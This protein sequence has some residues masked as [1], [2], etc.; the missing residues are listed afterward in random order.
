MKLK[1]NIYPVL[2]CEHLMIAKIC[3]YA[4]IASSL[5]LSGCATPGAEHTVIK[6]FDGTRLNLSKEASS[7]VVT[8]WWL[9][10]GDKNLNALITTA[11][12]DRPT[13]QIASARVQRAMSLAQLNDSAS[14]PQI[15]IGADLNRQGYS[16]NGLFGGLLKNTGLQ[17]ATTSSLQGSINWNIDLWGMHAAQT[18]AALGEARAVQADMATA[19][20][21]TSAQIAQAYI[22]LAKMG[23]QLDVAERAMTQR[24]EIYKLTR[25]RL[26]VG[27]DTKVEVAQA[28]SAYFEARVQREIVLE[29]IQLIRHQLAALSAQPMNA[30]DQVAPRLESLKLTQIPAVIGA[31]LLGRRSDVVAARL[32]VEA[33]T[34]DVSA[35][36]KQFYP[37]FNLV[38]F[39]G[40]NALKSNPLI[41]GN[42]RAF[43]VDPAISLPIFDGGRLRAQLGTKRAELDAAVANYNETVVQ[44]AREGSDQITSSQFIVNQRKEQKEALESAKSAYE[45]SLERYRAGLGNYLIVLNT[46]SQW[47][48]QQKMAVD[49]QARQLDSRVTLMRVLGGGWGQ[50]TLEGLNESQMTNQNHALNLDENLPKSQDSQALKISQKNKII[51]SKVV[52]QISQSEQSDQSDQSLKAQLQAQKSL[53]VQQSQFNTE[54]IVGHKNLDFANNDAVVN[55]Q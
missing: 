5:L 7:K 1:K 29:Q 23:T 35:A 27:L 46:E 20:L 51:E 49:L 37:N 34:Q 19:A 22:G 42:S 31:D 55:S 48:A 4:L 30:L 3:S 28:Q 11:L 44:A 6:E 53:D 2:A 18:A 17:T 32:R 50:L 14:M 10:F 21:W 16:T 38:G 12:K 52:G 45:L 8:Q 54:I 24:E 43:G 40:Y 9:E 41:T 13:L 33:A 39:A 47:L 36:T 26:E 25:S 15:G